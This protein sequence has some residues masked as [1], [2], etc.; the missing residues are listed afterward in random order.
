MYNDPPILQRRI[1]SRDSE[2]LSGPRAHS[3]IRWTK[4]WNAGG[5]TL[6]P[7]LQAL[8]LTAWTPRQLLVLEPSPIP[9]SGSQDR[10]APRVSLE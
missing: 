1:L 9:A 2:G 10:N 4:D 7:C 8:W 6:T 3:G 5:L